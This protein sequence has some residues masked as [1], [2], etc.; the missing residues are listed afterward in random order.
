MTGEQLQN[1][2]YFLSVYHFFDDPVVQR[3]VNKLRSLK[4]EGDSLG[5]MTI[6]TGHSLGGALAVAG[7]ARVN[8]PALVFSAPGHVFVAKYFDIDLTKVRANVINVQ[9]DNDVVVLVDSHVGATQEIAC[10][11]ITPVCHSSHSTMCELFRNCGDPRGRIIGV[12]DSET[13]GLE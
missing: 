3:V 10:T 4:E 6:A 9:P 12:P 13:C 11:E 7:A 8:T 5:F 2:M 1:V